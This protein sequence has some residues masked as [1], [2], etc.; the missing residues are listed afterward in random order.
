MLLQRAAASDG[1]GPV[2]GFWDRS[3]GSFATGTQRDFILRALDFGSSTLG[4]Q[5]AGAP[6]VIAATDPQHI[7]IAYLGAVLVG[8]RPAIMAMR[9]A[10]DSRDA[11]RARL[12]H[13]AGHLGPDTRV[14][15][16]LNGSSEPVVDPA[17]HVWHPIE[18][19]GAPSGRPL[20]P[21]SSPAPAPPDGVDGVLHYQMTSGSTGAGRAI[22]V[23]DANLFANIAAIAATIDL[24]QPGHTMV[25]WLPLY[26]DMGLVSFALMPLLSGI[27]FHLMR[28]YDFLSR[29]LSWLQAISDVGAT[30]ASA[31]NFVYDLLA[32]RAPQSDLRHLD[33]SRWRLAYCGAEPVRADTLRRFADALAPVGF[34]ADALKPTY[35]MAENTLLA[36]APGVEDD[37]RFVRTPTAD[38][39]QL[40]PVSIVAEGTL[41]ERTTTPDGHTDLVLLGPPALGVEVSIRDDDGAVIDEPDHCGEVYLSG[42][43]L[44][45]GIVEHGELTPFPDPYPTGDIGLL[46]DGELAIVD[47]IKNVII[48]DGENFSAQPVEQALA[49][50]TDIRLTNIAVFDS[51]IVDG[52][53]IA[54]VEMSRGEDPNA[55]AGLVAQH[56]RVSNLPLDR[57]IVLRRGGLPRTT[58]GKKQ[59]RAL[60][61]QWRDGTLKIV[62]DVAL[63]PRSASE[64]AS[65]GRDVDPADPESM[66]DRILDVDRADVD[67]F[68]RDWISAHL[69]RVGIDTV[70]TA[71][72]SLLH[73]Y[74]MDSLATIEFALAL[75]ERFAVSIG[76]H[77]IGELTTLAASVELVT[78]RLSNPD[79]GASISDLLARAQT[80][81]P[82]V[83][84]S[85]SAQTNRS[86]A[87]DGHDVS[88]LASCNYL[89]LD[90]DPEVQAS[91]APMVQR[92]GTHPSW[93]RA[94]ASPRPYHDL[95]RALARTAGVDTVAVF[96]T[97]TLLHIGVLPPLAGPTG[98]II[99]DSSAHASLQ[100]AAELAGARGT[101][102]TPVPH[103]DLTAVE[104]ALQRSS[105]AC[106]IIATN[107]VGSMSADYAPL[108]EYQRL[109]VEHDALV[110]VDD[111]HGFG[112]LGRD[113][114]DT[115]PYG[116]G[117]GGLVQ[118][119]GL[120]YDRIVYVA[121][122]S[123]AFSTM[124]AFVT[125]TGGLTQNLV[126]TAST[127]VFSGPIPVASIATGL[128]GLAVNAERGDEMR[129]E[130]HRL[131]QRLVTGLDD[132]GVGYDNP[133]GFPIVNV[134]VGGLDAVLAAAKTMWDF[135][136]LLTPSVFPAAPIDRGGLRFT[137]TAVNTDADVDRVIDAFAALNA[138]GTVEPV[139][140][141]RT[142]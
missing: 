115:L 22:A 67:S 34:S 18:L 19:P 46:H 15:M 105:A 11:S 127:M 77:S 96:A 37:A 21:S 94:V 122:M 64:A 51:E 26:H 109:A 108:A 71:T 107:G 131:T 106:K 134:P 43:S 2:V 20:P 17:G 27:D 91:I 140:A 81:L 97:I 44:C 14:L 6:V 9:P 45:P 84:T 136:V 112:V 75:E 65:D 139:A 119:L 89:G 80:D 129:G 100:E 118:H 70:I 35:G 88:D 8:A 5:A 23:S 56:Q 114:D 79:A 103:A 82:Q 73:D 33:L 55:L 50:H 7:L 47:R 132:L 124:A 83:F 85:V 32:E 59:H 137:L 53:L 135:G 69:E 121:G 61:Q 102:I 68:A 60:R 86:L 110:Y 141:E 49:Q 29:P 40:G 57:V 123:K 104:R 78:R 101:T 66:L 117:G 52:D 63:V 76:E 24:E 113:P 90:L 92:W 3:S 10:F 62:A 72:A 116:Y 111:A 16:Q 99:I 30:V 1:P 93:T 38:L 41:Q 39:V 125:L 126:N 4:D 54:A 133:S 138:E 58:S 120:D 87:I 13:I 28:P 130:L 12:R 42:S 128:T 48:R 74:D 36:T 31:P 142:G 98:E 25:T 95:E